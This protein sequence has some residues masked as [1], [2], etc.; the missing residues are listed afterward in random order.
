MIRGTCMRHAL[1]HYL[2]VRD[3]GLAAMW[4]ATSCQQCL[5]GPVWRAAVRLSARVSYVCSGLQLQVYIIDFG[6]AKKY[7]D[8]KSHIH[9]QCAARAGHY[10]NRSP[11]CLQGPR[12]SDVL[13][14]RSEFGAVV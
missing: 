2:H 4:Y 10:V 8:P 12:E 13:M 11:T 1:L 14:C 6:L 5:L 7:R 3:L 9:I